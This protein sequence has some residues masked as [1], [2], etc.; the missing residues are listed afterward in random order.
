ML[1]ITFSL[2]LSR[3]IS[4]NMI[5]DEVDKDVGAAS[6]ILTFEVFFVGAMAM[7][8]IA[9]DWPS[10]PLTIAVFALIGSFVPF[11]VLMVMRGNQN[12]PA[13]AR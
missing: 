10:K 2:G 5:L 3:P 8:M 11:A 12:R 7:E 4:N 6:S 13:S 1:C 9:F